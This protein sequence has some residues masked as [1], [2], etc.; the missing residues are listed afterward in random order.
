[1]PNDQTE[2]SPN[3]RSVMGGASCGLTYDASLLDALA[4]EDRLRRPLRLRRWH[5]DASGAG[6]T[7]SADRS[8]PVPAGSATTA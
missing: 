6:L 7:K 3:G 1:M 5:S 2:R 4:R 8:E